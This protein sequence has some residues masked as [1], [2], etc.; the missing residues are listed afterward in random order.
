MLDSYSDYVTPKILEQ[1]NIL[2]AL[3]KI[4]SNQYYS[5]I[6]KRVYHDNEETYETVIYFSSKDDFDV[7]IASHTGIYA[8][9]FRDKSGILVINKADYYQVLDFKT[10]STKSFRSL[11][12]TIILN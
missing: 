8:A 5:I 2:T 12:E 10:V 7:Y 3:L 1:V 4:L 6:S 11:F 9:A